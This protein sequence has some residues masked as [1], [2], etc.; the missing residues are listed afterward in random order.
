MSRKKKGQ[1]LRNVGRLQKSFHVHDLAMKK[2]IDQSS[3]TLSS[4]KKKKKQLHWILAHQV[5]HLKKESL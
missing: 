5:H 1:N 3:L 2:K 4:K